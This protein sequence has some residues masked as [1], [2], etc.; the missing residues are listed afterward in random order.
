MGAWDLTICARVDVALRTSATRCIA[1]VDWNRASSM[2]F[3][4]T[5]SWSRSLA[6][7]LAWCGCV[8]ERCV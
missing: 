5:A 6:I 4:S 3:L 1:L 2:V 7:S 8:C